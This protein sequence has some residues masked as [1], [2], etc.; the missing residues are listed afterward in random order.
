MVSYFA[1]LDC[2]AQ[3][4]M[5]FRGWPRFALILFGEA[6]CCDAILSILYNRV[7]PLVYSK[8]YFKFEYELTHTVFVFV[9]VNGRMLLVLIHG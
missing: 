4:T 2:S 3:T 5:K 8:E 7:P 9:F 1:T 6:L